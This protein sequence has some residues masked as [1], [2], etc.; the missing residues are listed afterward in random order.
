LARRRLHANGTSQ[1]LNATIIDWGNKNATIE[2]KDLP[3]FSKGGYILTGDFNGDGYPDFITYGYSPQSL[4][5]YP[6]FGNGWFLYL[7]DPLTDSYIEEPFGSDNTEFHTYFYA[8]DVNGDGKDELNTIIFL[9]YN[10][11]R[12]EI[13][14]Q[15]F[16]E[17]TFKCKKKKWKVYFILYIVITILA[18]FLLPLWKPGYLP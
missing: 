15:K 6:P 13:I 7:Y 16:S 1:R 4:P 5:T 9:R 10:N 18:C 3:Y 2:E 11:N 12:M 14:K 17:D 8:Q